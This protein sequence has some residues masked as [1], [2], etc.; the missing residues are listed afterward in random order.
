MRLLR[1]CP[2]GR[3]WA[4]ARSEAAR[5]AHRWL[6]FQTV[7]RSAPSRASRILR[8]RFLRLLSFRSLVLSLACSFARMLFRLLVG[9]PVRSFFCSFRFCF[10]RRFCVSVCLP[11]HPSKRRAWMPG[12]RPRPVGLPGT[13]RGPG[14]RWRRRNGARRKLRRL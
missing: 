12:C 11:L 9:S 1:L 5:P 8:R 14:K 10:R 6:C 13:R 2:V 3:M 4:V 7:P